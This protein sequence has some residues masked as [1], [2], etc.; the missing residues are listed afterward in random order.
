MTTN[1]TVAALLV[2]GLMAAGSP[3]ALAETS[4]SLQQ[5]VKQN[6]VDVQVK[7]LGGAT[8]NTIRVEVQSKIAGEVRVHVDP[9]TVFISTTGRVQNMTGGRIKGEF[10]TARTYRPGSVMVLVDNKRRSYCVEAF[11]LDYHKKPPRNGDTFSL[12]LNDARANRILSAPKDTSVSVW[13]YQTALWMDRA[14]VSPAELKRRYPR[15]VTDVE[16]RAARGMLTHAQRTG[17]AGIPA[18]IPA[19]VRVHVERIFSAD[20]AARKKAIESLGG[21]GERARPALPL[22]AVNVVSDTPGRWTPDT[23]VEVLADPNQAADALKQLGL[24]GLE[25]WIRTFAGGQV[26]IPGLTG[27][28]TDALKIIRNARVERLIGSLKSPLPGVRQRA[29]MVLGTLN[30]ARAVE[31]L[32]A[33]LKD[34]DKRLVSLAAESLKTITGQDFGTDQAKWRAWSKKNRPSEAAPSQPSTPSEGSTPR[35]F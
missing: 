6:M 10:V 33:V 30:D 18:G 21:M 29:A 13:A 1:K 27:D 5:A 20:P 8:G 23:I 35:E 11:C 22:V 32:I 15:R 17:I 34:A 7:S 9:G 24:P 25:S 16:V 3:A 26:E 14:G 2:A 12:A 31:P 4:I 19:D 28:P